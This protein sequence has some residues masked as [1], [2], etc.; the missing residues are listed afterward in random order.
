MHACSPRMNDP[1]RNP[2]VIEMSYLIA[3]DEILEECGAAR[4]GLQ[5]VL[6]IG[7]RHALIRGE[8]RVRSPSDLVKF[9]TGSRL[10]IWVGSTAFFLWCFH[11]MV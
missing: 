10:N 6:I 1:L 7:N 3:K 8:R 5:R 11:G 9:T 4:I 2:F